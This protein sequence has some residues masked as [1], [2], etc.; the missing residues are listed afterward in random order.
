MNYSADRNARVVGGAPAIVVETDII[1]LRANGQMRKHANVDTAAEA[2]RE[3]IHRGASKREVVAADKELR[4]RS[5]LGGVLEVYAR[6]EKVGVGVKGGAAGRGVV[7]AKIGDR[8][9]ER[10]RIVGHGTADAVL[11]YVRAAAEAEVGVAC[12]NING[13]RARGNG[14]KKK[15]R[16]KKTEGKKKQAFHKVSFLSSIE[17]VEHG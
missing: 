17:V 9:H 14:E 3:I 8:A 12:G 6:P 13:L 4:K 7:V 5:D 15:P 1:E 11:I 10:D 16:A 2:I